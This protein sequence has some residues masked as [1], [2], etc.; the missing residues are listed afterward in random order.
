MGLQK[1]FGEDF[2]QPWFGSQKLVVFREFQLAMLSRKNI[3]HQLSIQGFKSR[4]LFF[5][6]TFGAVVWL[7]L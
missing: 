6:A 2:R 4:S 1:V 5:I 3:N 7:Q